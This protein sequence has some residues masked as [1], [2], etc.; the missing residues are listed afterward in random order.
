MV[1]IG[2]NKILGS[3]SE[4]ALQIAVTK[5]ETG[6]FTRVFSQLSSVVFQVSILCI[7]TDVNGTYI[8]GWPLHMC[9]EMCMGM[10]FA[11]TGT[12]RHGV[13]LLCCCVY[14]MPSTQKREVQMG[15][16]N[17][18]HLLYREKNQHLRSAV[19]CETT[20]ISIP[21][22]LLSLC[23]YLVWHRAPHFCY[24]MC[25]PVT[26]GAIFAPTLMTTL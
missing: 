4:G 25:G 1:L 2:L 16:P 19:P 3:N 14:G 18:L 26:P 8:L 11:D 22:L 20:T 17:W 21:L 5:K 10:L 12:H 23:L 7:T 15:T 13:C 24:T 9:V 6:D